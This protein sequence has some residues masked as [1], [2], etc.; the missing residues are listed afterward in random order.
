MK[1][2]LLL[3]GH[4]DRGDGVAEALIFE[5]IRLADRSYVFRDVANNPV[6]VL[7][8]FQL[9]VSCFALEPAYLI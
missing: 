8:G 7:P 4:G 9:N 5:Y 2:Y 1:R 3:N 6:E